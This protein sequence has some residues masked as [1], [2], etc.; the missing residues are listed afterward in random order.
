VALGRGLGAARQARADAHAY[1]VAAGRASG[2][3]THNADAHLDELPMR[4]Q[5]PASA[6]RCRGQLQHLLAFVSRREVRRFHLKQIPLVPA[7]FTAFSATR[8]WRIK[9]VPRPDAIPRVSAQKSPAFVNR[10]E[11]FNLDFAAKSWLM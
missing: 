2:Q 1:Q 5:S 11:G 9:K 6:S 3:G 8:C 4:P 7:A 10:P